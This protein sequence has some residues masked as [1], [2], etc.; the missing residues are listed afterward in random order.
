MTRALQLIWAVICRSTAAP[1][2]LCRSTSI[3][4]DSPTSLR[5]RGLNAFTK[6]CPAAKLFAKHLKIEEHVVHTFKN[7]TEH[8]SVVDADYQKGI[9]FCVN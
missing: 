5:K 1:P 8:L 6:E 9:I 3:S 7:L 4:P 2:S